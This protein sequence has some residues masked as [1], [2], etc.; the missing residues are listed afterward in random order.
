M[1]E[2]GLARGVSVD[3]ELPGDEHPGDLLHLRVCLPRDTRH[4]RPA[5]TLLRPT[6]LFKGI[7]SNRYFTLKHNI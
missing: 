4:H 1:V 5:H 6:R 3:P 2:R 7:L